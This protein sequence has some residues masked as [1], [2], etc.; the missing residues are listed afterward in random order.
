MSC[1]SGV[2]CHISLCLLLVEVF[3]IPCEPC[4]QILKML[5]SP[6]RL[7]TRAGDM[8]PSPLYRLS[9]SS[10]SFA[11]FQMSEP[12][13]DLRFVCV[14]FLFPH[15]DIAHIICPLF[16]Y[17]LPVADV[18]DWLGFLKFFL[19]TTLT[20]RVKLRELFLQCNHCSCPCWSWKG[21]SPL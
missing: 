2:H 17:I 10:L 9:L 7:P 8:S 16:H 3:A 14:A 20:C 12:S 6:P 18:K 15:V 19:N 5:S 13:S 11:P 4:Y 21:L 1:V